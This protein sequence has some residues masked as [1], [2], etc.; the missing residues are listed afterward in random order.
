MCCGGAQLSVVPRH[1]MT[2]HASLLYDML[3]YDVIWYATA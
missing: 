1:A 2:C 3:V